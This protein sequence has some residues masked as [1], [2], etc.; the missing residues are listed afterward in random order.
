MAVPM[1]VTALQLSDMDRAAPKETIKNR[2]LD[3]FRRYSH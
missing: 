1:R 3:N 2:R